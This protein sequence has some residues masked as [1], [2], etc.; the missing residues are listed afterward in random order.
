MVIPTVIMQTKPLERY[1]HYLQHPGDV[2]MRET[3]VAVMYWKYMQK[4]ITKFVKTCDRCQKG[5]FAKRKYGYLVPKIAVLDPWD[6]VC[7]NLIVPYTIKAKDKT[8]MD[9][10]CLTI[11][12]PATSWFEIVELPNTELTYDTCTPDMI[13]KFIA[14]VGWAIRS[15]HHTVL[16]SSPGAAIFGQDIL[17]DIPNLADWSQIGKQ[18][19][20]Q[21]DKSNAR[22]NASRIDFD[23][24]IGNRVLMMLEGINRKAEDKNKG[25]FTITEVFCNGTVG[26]QRGTISERINI[27]RLKPYFE[28][29]KSNV[30]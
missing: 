6:Q 26:I 12:D 23:Y 8:I 15:T 7:V 20:E 3:L 4:H 11:I 17:F 1:H 10:M 5:K 19:Q 24:K 9:F 30:P 27:R 13:D 14:N 28:Y 16:G 21:V 25:P 2:R 29:F 22:E 18:R